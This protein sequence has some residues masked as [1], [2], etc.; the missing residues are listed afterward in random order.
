MLLPLWDALARKYPTA[1]PQLK[2]P[3]SLGPW[4]S[5]EEI[6]RGLGNGAKGLALETKS[7]LS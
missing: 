1:W 2:L 3:H 6:A 7:L 5:R 4:F